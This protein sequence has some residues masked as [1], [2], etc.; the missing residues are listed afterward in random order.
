VTELGVFSRELARPTLE[1][2]LDAVRATGATVVQYK[3]ALDLPPAAVREA[4]RARGLRVGALSGTYNMAHP[5]PFV[6]ADG[7]RRLAARI[8]DAPA[9]DADVVTLCT[10]T[11]DPVDMWRAHP[12]NGTRE[13]WSDMRAAVDAA[14]AVAAAHG[15]TLGVEPE[16][17]NVVAD[18]RAA[19]RLLD[20]A[21]S[22][23]LRIVVDAANLVGGR[24]DAERAILDEAFDLL[25][26]DVVLA[27]LKDL[28][29][30]VDRYRRHLAATGDPPLVLHGLPADELAPAIARL[31][32]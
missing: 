4:A 18:A 29:L 6:R 25:G 14:L 23:H 31:R 28:R 26:G 9:Y 1:A 30:D 10:G 19:R 3:P 27:H 17:G 16:P 13:A 11:R 21:G 22:P 12:D 32:A 15:V 7:A 5:D 8:A 2:T 20:E 24:Y